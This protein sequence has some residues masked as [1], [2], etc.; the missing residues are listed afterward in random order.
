MSALHDVEDAVAA[1]AKSSKG[2][3]ATDARVLTKLAELKRDA[4]RTCLGGDGSLSREPQ[5]VG[6]KPIS[7]APAAEPPRASG[8]R[9]PSRTSSPL[10]PVSVPPLLSITFCDAAGCWVND[11]TRLQRIGPAL[12][13]PTG[14]CSVHGSVLSCP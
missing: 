8:P 7:A 1:A 5:H 9:L 10:P 14:F 11:G 2:T 3:H 12:I 6:Q 13:G 4:A